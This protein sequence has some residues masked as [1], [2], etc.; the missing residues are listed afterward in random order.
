MAV[1]AGRRWSHTATRSEE[2]WASPSVSN[3]CGASA[4]SASAAPSFRRMKA[5]VVYREAVV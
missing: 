1:D 2:A 5:L 3:T 4:R